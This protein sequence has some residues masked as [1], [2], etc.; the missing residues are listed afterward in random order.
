MKNN[1]FSYDLVK[2]SFALELSNDIDMYEEEY[3]TYLKDN[4]FDFEFE[5]NNIINTQ[6][7]YN[8]DTE[9]DGFREDCIRKNFEKIYSHFPKGKYFGQWGSDHTYLRD[10]GGPDK[11]DNCFATFLNSGFEPTKGKVISIMYFY[12]DSK[13]MIRGKKH[14]EAKVNEVSKVGI[15]AEE[16]KDDYTLIRF[17]GEG[18]PFGSKPFLVSCPLEGGTKDYY[19]FGIL[20]KNSPA[21]RPYGD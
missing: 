19:Q 17:D 4:F 15:L 21:T 11:I 7:Y 6:K 5:V 9:R 20:I 10:R 2:N 18:A 16:S 14:G 8:M 13:S 1:C 12:K 3:K